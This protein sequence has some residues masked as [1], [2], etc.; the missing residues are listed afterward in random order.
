MQPS[1][2]STRL[3]NLAE[4]AA[5]LF[6]DTETAPMDTHVTATGSSQQSRKRSR[7]RAPT[8]VSPP[9]S[10]PTEQEVKSLSENSSD[11]NDDNPLGEAETPANLSKEQRYEESRSM[12]QT[13][14]HF[15]PDLL[16]PKRMPSTPK[17][18]NLAVTE[19]YQENMSSKFL[20]ATNQVFYK[21]VCSNWIPSM[22]Y[23]S[24][25]QERL[26]F[27]YMLHH[28]KGGFA[29]GKL[30]YD[31]IIPMGENTKTKRTRRIM[32]PTL[33]Q[34]VLHFQQIIP[35]DTRDDEFTGLPKLVMKD[36]KDGRGT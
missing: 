11:D 4:V 16:R 32:F 27:V 9:P 19:R 28:H 7:F 24:M 3:Q 29:F 2:R 8:V 10:E 15:Y 35:P 14:A 20:T 13:K 17:F 25:N 18:I 33:I 5:A 1:R 26:K 22:N 23:T 36:I 21:L 34:Q 30:V 6:Q 31:Q 12:Y